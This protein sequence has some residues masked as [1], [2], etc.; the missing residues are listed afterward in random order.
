MIQNEIVTERLILRPL[1]KEDNWDWLEIFNSKNVGKFISK[2]DNIEKI[3]KL[4]ENRIEKYKAKKGQVFSI[5]EKNTAKVIGTI[6]L[7]YLDD[8][9]AEISYVMNYKFWNKGFATESSKSLI[10]YAFNVLNAKKIVADCLETNMS[11][12]HILKDKL[13]MKQ[14]GIETRIDKT[15]NKPLHFVCFELENDD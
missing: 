1:K 15:S 3:D 8:N 9:C 11:S 6:E 7:K 4:I 12:M 5:V 13:Q 14:T 10:D 2:I